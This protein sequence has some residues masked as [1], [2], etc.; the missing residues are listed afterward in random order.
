MAK[1]EEEKVKDINNHFKYLKDLRQPYESLWDKC[2]EYGFHS[3][4]MMTVGKQGGEQTGKTIY[5]STAS[6]ELETFGNGLYGN[7]LGPGWF[8]STLPMR[9]DFPRTSAMRQYNSK[10]LDEIPEISQW[11]SDE[12]DV[13]IA[14]VQASNFY[15]VAPA[16]FKS[17]GCIGTVVLE[18]EEDFK[19]DKLHFSIPHIRE[20]YVGRDQFGNVDTLFREYDICLKDANSKFGEAVMEKALPDFKQRM[21]TN[22]WDKITVL[23]AIYPR[24]EYNA[25]SLRAD[26]MPVASV[27]IYNSKILL[28]SGY[29]RQKFICWDYDRNDDE[30]Y[31][32]SAIANAINDVIMAN[33]MGKSNIYAGARLADPP[34]A[35]QESLRGRAFFGPGGKTYFRANEA[36]PVPMETGLRGL[37]VALEFQ[38]DVRN[39]IKK[40]LCTD[41]FLMMNNAMM[42]NHNLREAQVYEMA[43]EK[44]MILAPLT[45]RIEKGLLDKITDIFFDFEYKAGPDGLPTGRIPTPPDILLEIASQMRVKIEVDYQGNLSLARKRFYKTQGLRTAIQDVTMIAQL[46]PE[47]LDIP[48]FDGLTRDALKDS[49]SPERIKDEKVV[50]ATRRARAKQAAEM[51][52]MQVAAGMADAVPKL[53]KPVEKGSVLSA[54]TGGG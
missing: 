14:A 10:S 33:S 40:W 42:E 48:D 38:K 16:V 15:E 9:V 29:P 47:V 27:W 3:K 39:S 50:E 35:M 52:A 53:S 26:Q 37:P 2:I 20:C 19:N 5:D 30:A 25:D 17:G 44:A 45:E 46:K 54:I 23:H 28:E 8:K 51:Q 11:L 12:Q 21:E 7:M 43:G 41:I 34:Y 6:L 13:M 49:I 22:P 18:S 36:A 31:A 24:T 4:R 32:R 1:S